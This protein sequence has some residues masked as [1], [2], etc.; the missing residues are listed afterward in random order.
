MPLWKE[1]YGKWTYLI[2]DDFWLTVVKLLFTVL[3]FT[4]PLHSL[5]T[6][7]SIDCTFICR[8][9]LISIYRAS[10][11]HALL[12]YIYRAPL[13]SPSV[14]LYLPCL[15]IY[16]ASRFTVPLY[17]PWVIKILEL[18]IVRYPIFTPHI[19][20]YQATTILLFCCDQQFE[21]TCTRF[22]VGWAE[23]SAMAWAKAN[24]IFEHLC[25]CIWRISHAVIMVCDFNM[26]SRLKI[27]ML[28]AYYDVCFT[29]SL[30]QWPSSESTTVFCKW[31]LDKTS[32]HV[33]GV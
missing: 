1:H 31:N 33:Y 24:W 22:E 3:L 21:Q 28:A 15:S 26:S 32:Y 7:P 14:P 27:R 16:R 11:Y 6:V 10:I 20:R 17:L 12:I 13:I 5:F 4:V 19:R 9:F 30:W 25:L 2:D 29:L 8:G 23:V 18:W